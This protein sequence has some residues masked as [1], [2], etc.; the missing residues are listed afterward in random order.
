MFFSYRKLLKEL[1]IEVFYGP[2]AQPGRI[3]IQE[4]LGT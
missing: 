3:F 1:L 4:I 2:V